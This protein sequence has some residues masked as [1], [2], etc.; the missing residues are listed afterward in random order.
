MISEL[1]GQLAGSFGIEAL[2]RSRDA[3]VQLFPARN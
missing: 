3:R 1:T 2:D